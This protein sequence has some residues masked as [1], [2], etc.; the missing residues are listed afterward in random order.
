MRIRH[1][2]LTLLL[3]IAAAPLAA[4]P[5]AKKLVDQV[6]RTYGGAARWKSVVDITESGKIFSAMQ[7]EG[8]VTRKWVRPDS[9]HV[10]LT[11]A[12]SSETRIVDGLSGSRDGVPVDGPQLDA[13]ILQT[14]RIALPALLLDH[15]KELR[16]GGQRERNGKTLDVIEVPLTTYMAVEIEIDPATHR[17]LRSTG[18]AAVPGTSARLEFIAVYD[19]FREVDGILFAFAEENFANGFRTGVTTLETI[20]VERSTTSRNR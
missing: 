13:M 17:I 12:T 1:G 14:A 16:D 19:D 8:T 15:A 5:P 20:E 2:I 10:T 11:Y 6:L 18:R 9:L 4:A 7:G 3:L